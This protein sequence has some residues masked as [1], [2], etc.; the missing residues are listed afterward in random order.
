LGSFPL[1]SE[2]PLKVFISWPEHDYMP[3][4]GWDEKKKTFKGIDAEIITLLCAEAK[5]KF[6]YVY[7]KTETRLPRIEVLVRN[8]ADISIR[9]FSI[10][11]KRKQYIDFT[12]PYF[13]DGLSALVHKKSGITSIEQ[14]NGKKVLAYVNTTG[15]KY[16]KENKLTPFIIT[17]SPNVMDSDLVAVKKKLVDAYINDKVYLHTLTKKSDE[18][19][20]LNTYLTT[21][22]WGIGVKKGNTKLLNKLNKALKVNLEN[23]KIEAIFDKYK[24]PFRHLNK[25]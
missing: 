25:K 6:K 20:V 21:E 4:Y 10:T 7:P 19:K 18:V 2:K 9:S 24:I 14:L 3:F 1:S 23:K 12:N 11:E 8:M 13:Y 16:V 15:Y 5:L 17:T 22:P